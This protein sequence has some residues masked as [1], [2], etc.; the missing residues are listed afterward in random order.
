MSGPLLKRGPDEGDYPPIKGRL[1]IHRVF[2]HL[3][4]RLA[5]LPLSE[6]G[7]GK[8]NREKLGFFSSGFDLP[9]RPH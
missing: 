5:L 9:L 6:M 4:T 2:F 1:Q 3:P 8:Q 7:G